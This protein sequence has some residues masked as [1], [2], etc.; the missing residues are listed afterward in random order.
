MKKYL[1]AISILF[2]SNILWCQNGGIGH[3]EIL[4]KATVSWD[5]K[6]LPYYKSGTPEITILKITIPPGEQLPIHK[7]PVINAGVLLNGELT[8]ITEKKDTLH[9]K[10]GVGL[11]EV[12]DTW[13]YGK[14]EGNTTAE[15]LV[16]YAG[17]Q[18]EPITIKKE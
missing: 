1:I 6:N 7:H 3:T 17:I 15:I 12:V 10:A 5:G 4:S 8:V 14:N 11:I 9:L 2:L 18:G 13:H 16:F